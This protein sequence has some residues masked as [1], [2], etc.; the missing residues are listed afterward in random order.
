MEFLRLNVKLVVD[1]GI[2]CVILIG[3]L[4]VLAGLGLWAANGLFVWILMLWVVG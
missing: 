1:H 3:F 2:W 4:V